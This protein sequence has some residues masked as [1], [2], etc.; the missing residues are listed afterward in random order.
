MPRSA[1]G[2]SILANRRTRGIY[3][4]TRGVHSPTLNGDGLARADDSAR[5]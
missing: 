4:P 2:G 1:P 3:N 5:K